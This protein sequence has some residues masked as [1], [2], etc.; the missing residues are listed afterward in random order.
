[1]P[2]SPCMSYVPAPLPDERPAR[3]ADRL[4][5]HYAYHASRAHRRA[6]GQY[7]TTPDIAEFMAGLC[8]VDTPTLSVLDPGAG[9]GTLACALC[10]YLACHTSVKAISLD[11]YETDAALAAMLERA[12]HHLSAYLLRRGCALSYEV[13][14]DDFVLSAREALTPAE[15]LFPG[16]P[17]A[18]LY[19]VAIGNPPYFKIPK[20]DPRAKA[21]A[22]VVHGQPNIYAL[23]MAASAG[24]LRVKGQLIFITPRSFASGPYFRLFRERFFFRMRPTAL[25]IFESRAEAFERDAVL[26][27]NVILVARR[28]DGW[29]GRLGVEEDGVIVSVC[30]GSSDLHRR[31]ERRVPLSQVL[32]LGGTDRILTIATD[33]ET[34][35]IRKLVQSWPGS[36]STYGLQVSTGPVVAFRA[37]DLLSDS[38]DVR[39]HAPLLW[40]HNVH[41]MSVTW[42]RLGTRKPQYVRLGGRAATLLVPARTYVLLRRF[43]SKEEERRLVAAPLAREQLGS[44][45][46][47]LEN[48]LNYIYRPHG[49]LSVNEAWG[50]AV[51][52]N[53][54]VL[55]LYFRAMNGST[56][57]SATELRT[58]PLPSLDVIRQIGRLAR[59][60]KDPLREAGSLVL[61]AMP[62]VSHIAQGADSRV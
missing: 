42:P 34:D 50:L 25:H 55:D 10:E 57:V 9:T 38:G 45:L 17:P 59:A 33:D 5:Q 24:V 53:S 49:E 30:N 28:D 31:K 41:P 52:Y 51:L 32:S 20:S 13:V 39:T 3:Y 29:L 37:R 46:V 14:T 58:M 11:A 21:A 19:D 15:G 43:S 7:F 4:A 36:L 35:A 40:M 12:L 22:V 1:M 2:N 18:R 61:Y 54:S 27:E 44:A 47:G 48:H 56:Q 26:Q 62:G 23:F 16:G 8:S 60:S 6:Y